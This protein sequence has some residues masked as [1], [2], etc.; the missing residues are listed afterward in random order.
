MS[1]FDR[2]RHD[3]ATY[4]HLLSTDPRRHPWL[5]WGWS[6]AQIAAAQQQERRRL[7]GV[8]D[9]VARATQAVGIKPCTPCKRRQATLNRWFP[10]S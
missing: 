4:R 6:P 9:V 8:G 5:R 7:R 10:F 1:P 3:P 2:Y